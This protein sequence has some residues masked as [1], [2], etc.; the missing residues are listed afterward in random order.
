MTYQESYH[1]VEEAQKIPL[2]LLEIMKEAEHLHIQRK[3]IA[4]L[5]Q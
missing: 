2:N 5:E 4:L 3:I 1:P